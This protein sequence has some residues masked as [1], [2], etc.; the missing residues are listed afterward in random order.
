MDRHRRPARSRDLPVQL[1][2]GRR[3]HSRPR[4]SPT[5]RTAGRSTPALWRCPAI[6]RAS[7]SCRLFPMARC[8]SA[9]ISRRRSQ[10]P[11]SSTS[12][13]R[14]NTTPSPPAA[15]RS[16]ISRHGSGDNEENWSD[17]GRAG[18]I[19][20]NLIAQHK[21]GADADRDAERRYGRQ[22]GRREFCRKGS[23]SSAGRCS[24][25]SSR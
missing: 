20:D 3:A 2:G 22:L 21:A 9:P 13:R 18:V 4:Q 10:R 17:T 12:I 11:A 8:T 6:R 19:L 16:S 24:R 14:R 1:R 15:F 7:T 5:S 25:T 23:K